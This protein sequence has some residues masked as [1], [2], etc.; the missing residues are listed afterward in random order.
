MLLCRAVCQHQSFLALVDAVTEVVMI[1]YSVV[2]HPAGLV[3]RVV[4]SAQLHLLGKT[5]VSQHSS[6]SAGGDANDRVLG[7]ARDEGGRRLGARSADKRAKNAG[8]GK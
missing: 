7:R 8:R 5:S 3:A 1:P 4:P 2:E 6:L